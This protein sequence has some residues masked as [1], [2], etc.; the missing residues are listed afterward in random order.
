MVDEPDEAEHL[1][2]NKGAREK[3]KSKGGTR[4]GSK[5]MVKTNLRMEKDSA[6]GLHETFDDE[7]NWIEAYLKKWNNIHA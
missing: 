2:E 4:V 7:K 6:P 5:S 1:K 3:Q